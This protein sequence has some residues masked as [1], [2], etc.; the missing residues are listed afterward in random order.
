[1]RQKSISKKLTLNKQTVINLEA[2]EMNSVKG[3]TLFSFTCTMGEI[4]TK[5]IVE[6]AIAAETIEHSCYIIC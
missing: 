5:I 1:M 2:T 4:C 6:V 3:G